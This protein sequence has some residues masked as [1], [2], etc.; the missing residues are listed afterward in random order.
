[1]FSE[2]LTSIL[3]EF[4]EM[5]YEPTTLCR[6]PTQEAVEWKKNLIMA[7]EDEIKGIK[8]RKGE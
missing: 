4:D 7:I 1:M 2:C 8:E 3:T 5:G 6:N